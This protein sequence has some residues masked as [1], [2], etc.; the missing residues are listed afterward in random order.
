MATS[1]VIYLGELRANAEHLASGNIIVTD[2]PIDNHG[3][4]EA[5][6]P[7]D[8]AATSLASCMITVL[9]IYCQNNAIDMK[10]TSAEVTKIM[11]TEGPRRIVGIDVNLTIK[12]STEMDEKHRII[13]E[14]VALTCPV[15]LSLH[16]DLKQTININFERF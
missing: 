13:L 4:G 6:S 5:F 1:K 2:A 14:R 16:P 8:L 3:K 9:G 15:S 12:T 10:G 11:N 7:T